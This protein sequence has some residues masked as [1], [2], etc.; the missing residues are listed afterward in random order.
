MSYKLSTFEFVERVKSWQQSHG[1]HDL[2]W[3]SNPSPYSVLVSEIM[4]Q[5]TQVATVIPYFE[6]WMEQFPTLQ[7]LALAT[8]DQVLSCWQG[9]GYY[10]RARNLHRAAQFVV[11]EYAGDIPCN[12]EQLRMIPGIGPYTAGAILAFAFNQ[13]GVI[14]DGNIKRLFTRYF[15]IFGAISSTKT[16]NLIWAQAEA[17]TPAVDNRQFAQGLLDL[18]AT[19]CKPKLPLCEACPLQPSCYA[20]RQNCIDQLPERVQKKA[21][22]KRQ[23]HFIWDFNADGILLEQRSAAGIWPRL[24]SLPEIANPLENAEVLGTFDHVFSHYKLHATVWIHRPDVLTEDQQR[25]SLATLQTLGLPAPIRKFIES[26][27]ARRA[28]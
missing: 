5:Q 25:V 3:Q 28:D 22:P 13:R 24:W 18:G 19:L 10:S 23:G 6:R 20:H 4:L 11:E 27:I 17:V 15:G 14:V 7:E 26:Q 2:P 12:N 8:E 1:R 21:I 9:L 16:N